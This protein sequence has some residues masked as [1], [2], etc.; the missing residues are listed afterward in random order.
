MSDGIREIEVDLPDVDPAWLSLPAGLL[1]A[2]GVFEFAPL[3]ADATLMLA[4]TVFCVALWIG[5]PVD[6]WFTALV[7]LGLIGVAF[8]TDLA[9]TGFQKPA[10]WLVV[11]GIL[12]GGAVRQSG[13]AE[14]VELLARNRT[15]DRVLTDAVVAYRYLLVGLCVASLGLAVLV[16]SSLVRVLILG[17]ILISLGDLFTERRPKVGLFLG[18]LFA[19]FYGASGIL[20][21]ALPNIIV[22]GL[23]ESS[24]GPAISWTEWL[25][26]LAPVMSVG[27]VLIVVAVAYLL[28]RPRDRD[29]VV[30]PERTE[31]V[32]VS[33]DELRMLAFL[34][35]G[36][37]VWMTD[38]LHGLHPLFGALAVAVLAFAPRIGVV[39][40]EAVADADFSILFFLGAIFAVAEGL[41]RTGFTDLAAGELLSYLPSDASFPIVL[42]FV[43]LIA[44]L[45]T[46]VMEGMAVASVLTPVLAS[47]AESAGVPL[48]PVA[49]MEAAAL[50]TYFFPYQSAVLVAILGMGVVDTVEL[51]RM[52]AAIAVATLLVLVPLQIGVF[53]V[54]F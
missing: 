23:V 21:G 28:Y 13:L 22:T 4:I 30:P 1:A 49:M 14:L 10:T 51:T 54:F 45:L 20:T 47:F 19:T 46:L 24:G 29:A 11:V 36:V 31:V 52:S 18:P 2:V 15:P 39:G 7:C 41:R 8:S 26:W 44:Q 48:V 12:I 9:L 25:R 43:V 37:A 33:A 17:P 32:T 3:A 42:L 27:R 5:S 35:V 34:L 16:P 53:A 40:S 50:N 38:S 6:P